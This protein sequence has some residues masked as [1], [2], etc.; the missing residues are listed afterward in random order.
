[1]SLFFE[2]IREADLPSNITEIMVKVCETENTYAEE[3]V[4]LIDYNNHD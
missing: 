2:K 3:S 1:M 4:C